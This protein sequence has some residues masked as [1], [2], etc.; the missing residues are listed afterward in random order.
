[1]KKLMT[2][3]FVLVFAGST[4]FAQ[5]NDA[6]VD[7]IGYD[8]DAEVE[9]IGLDNEVTL[10]QVHNHLLGTRGINDADVKQTGN[11]NIADIYQR[12][13]GQYAAS[14]FNNNLDLIQDGN[15][16]TA[17]TYQAIARGNDIKL[18]QFG[19][20]NFA[21]IYQH[22]GGKLSGY[23]SASRTVQ[24]GEGNELYIDMGNFNDAG[25]TQD[26]NFNLA[27]IKQNSF[28]SDNVQLMQEGDDHEVLLIQS[29]GMADIRQFGG[30]NNYVYGLVGSGTFA[31]QEGGSIM[32]VIQNGSLNELFI[33]QEAAGT[34]TVTQMGDNNTSTIEQGLGGS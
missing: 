25:I 2:L 13:R 3:L 24:D 16:N 28:S 5:N 14:G 1:M 33:G 18:D 31:H 9:Q 27:D 8:N 6:T 32:T 23:G 4:A 12:N 17:I 19:D 22:Q 15:L 21:D 20:G 26:G 29:E 30:N 10:E 34:A 11:T 7:Q